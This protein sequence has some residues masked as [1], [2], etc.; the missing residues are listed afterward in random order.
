MIIHKT[1]SPE[2]RLFIESVAKYG[3]DTAQEMLASVRD[4]R[5]LI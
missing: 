1:Y 3:I 5:D 4:G 2:Q